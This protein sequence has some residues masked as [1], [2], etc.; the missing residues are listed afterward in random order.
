MPRSYASAEGFNP[1]CQDETKKPSATVST[2]ITYDN[3]YT[4]SQT[5]QLI[6]LLT[7]IAGFFILTIN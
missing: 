3:V 2:Q 6:A 1:N 7:H 4:L 5:P